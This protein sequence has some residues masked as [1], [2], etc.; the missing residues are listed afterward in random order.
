MML[1]MHVIRRQI[2]SH[3]GIHKH[4]T[5]AAIKS[6]LTIFAMILLL[7]HF[8]RIFCCAALAAPE[9]SQMSMQIYI[10]MSISG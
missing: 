8:F 2:R 1:D 7:V 6:L 10:A 5:C 3:I 4:T 9:I